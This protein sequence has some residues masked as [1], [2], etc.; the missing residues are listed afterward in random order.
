MVCLIEVLTRGARRD[1]GLSEDMRA[2][3]LALAGGTIAVAGAGVEGARTRLEAR[4]KIGI[5]SAVDS[6]QRACAI[7][8][9]EIVL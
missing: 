3:G 2:R 1:I 7:L 4:G 6:S 9:G 5:T 8:D